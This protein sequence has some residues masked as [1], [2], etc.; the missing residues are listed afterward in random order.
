MYG[1]KF[2]PCIPPADDQRV[3]SG[4]RPF[5]CPVREKR[6][7]PASELLT[8][9]RVHTGERP[10]I[11]TVREKGFN[12]SSN[13][14]RHQQVH[15]IAGDR[16]GEIKKGTGGVRG[17]LSEI[18]G[19]VE[20]VCE[21]D[22]LLQFSMGAGHCTDAVLDVTAKESRDSANLY[23]SEKENYSKRSKCFSSAIYISFLSK[24]NPVAQ[25]RYSPWTQIAPPFSVMNIT[26]SLQA[27]EE[28]I[29]AGMIIARL[30]ETLQSKK[31]FPV[32]I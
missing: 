5:T 8:H 16:N 17:G 4:E 19:R 31:K 13:L 20:V 32:K 10:F 22:L 27:G 18:E 1:K 3:H 26:M 14:Q 29:E 2:T 23:P 21:V 6:V 30:M 11:C 28:G 25:G 15:V 9:Q 12:R 24:V 7:T